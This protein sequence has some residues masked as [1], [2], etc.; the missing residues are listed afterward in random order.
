MTFGASLEAWPDVGVAPWLEASLAV[1]L[2]SVA[3]SAPPGD[4][5]WSPGL[6]WPFTAADV[7]A[8]ANQGRMATQ[9]NLRMNILASPQ[10]SFFPVVAREQK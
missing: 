4:P 3:A 7:Q 9:A 6:S 1:D 10:V 8:D 2:E 5:P